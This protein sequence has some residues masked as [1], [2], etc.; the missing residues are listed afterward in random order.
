MK[1]IKTRYAYKKGYHKPKVLI[2]CPTK[3]DA[4]EIIKAI[5]HIY[6]GG[7]KKGVS[8]KSKNKF[9]EEYSNAEEKL[10]D[11]FRMGLTIN[12]DGVQLFTS[13]VESDIIVGSPLGIRNIDKT[14]DVNETIKALDFLSSIEMLLLFNSQEF[15]YQN[16]EHLEVVMKNV[17]KQ[18]TKIKDINDV[19]RIKPIF[20][21]GISKY[22]RQ[23]I[24]LGQFCEWNMLALLK[25]YCSNISGYAI[26][27]NFDLGNMVLLKIP[28]TRIMFKRIDQE[29]YIDTIN[30]KHSIFTTKLWPQ[31]KTTFSL[32]T[33]IVTTTYYDFLRLK[34]FFKDSAEPFSFISEH[35][36]QKKIQRNKSLFENTTNKYLLITERALHYKLCKVKYL[37]NLLLYGISNDQEVMI[38]LLKV[39]GDI[40]AI[41]KLHNIIGSSL[42]HSDGNQRI[43]SDSYGINIFYSSYDWMELERM[44]GT[45]N[46]P[47]FLQAKASQI[48]ITT[49]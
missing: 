15:S 34:K 43:E 27:K 21:D 25:K 41:Q 42:A 14:S 35:D 23:T 12:P 26:L 48:M 31:L 11:Y 1:P 13:F 22:V 24:V 49:I 20:L 30:S 28:N 39:V 8:K 46:L 29:S 36:S 18:P 4:H 45:A 7:W 5:I 10:S 47:A 3:G 38:S 33:L 9:I 40:N 6:L 2:L 17:N 37:N 44:V 16:L 32:Y 19:N